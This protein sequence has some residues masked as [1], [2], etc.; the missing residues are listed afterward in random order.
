MPVGFVTCLRIIPTC[1]GLKLSQETFDTIVYKVIKEKG[2]DLAA[3]QPRFIVD[4]IVA[5]CRLLG[6]EPY[7]E[8]RFIDD[9]LD[10]L[11]VRR[12]DG[13]KPVPPNP[14]RR[15]LEI[16]QSNSPDHRKTFMVSARNSW[17]TKFAST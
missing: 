6:Q 8:P 5:T 15:P 11:R 1:Q 9:A 3:Y 16:Q 14:A 7:F 13:A 12:Y 4:Q 17:R 10:N 2:L